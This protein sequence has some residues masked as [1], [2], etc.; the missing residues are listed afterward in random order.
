MEK[1]MTN[2]ILSKVGTRLGNIDDLPEELKKQIP[3]FA[4]GGLDEQVYNVLKE[5]LEG[6]ASLSEIMIALY[7]RY[8]VVDKNRQEV[9]EAVYRLIRK[10]VVAGVK[11]RKAVYKLASLMIDEC[12][13]ASDEHQTNDIDDTDGQ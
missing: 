11:G 5:E 7:Q 8:K 9:T 2:D 10:R 3:E 4:L 1:K 12:V 13:N 6:I